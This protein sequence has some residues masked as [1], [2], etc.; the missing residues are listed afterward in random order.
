MHDVLSIASDTPR[1]SVLPFTTTQSSREEEALA[2][3]VTLGITYALYAIT[4]RELFVVTPPPVAEERE[5][6]ERIA[7]AKRL[8]VRYLITG[9][10]SIDGGEVQVDVQ[11]LDANAGIVVWQDQFRQ[12]YA[13]AFKLQ[14]DISRRIVSSL[15]IELST[16]EWNR[17]QFL[18]DTE[19]LKAWLYAADG[20]RHLIRVTPQE[21][22]LAE[23]AYRNALE[24][25]P[26]YVSARRGLAWVAFLSVRLGWSR[27]RVAAIQE[28]ENQ[29]NVVLRK[30]PDDGTSL[31]LKG[32]IL[33]LKEQY[34]EAIESGR[35]AT[36]KL[37]GSADA[38]AVLAHTLTYVG[39]YEDA[40]K[41]IDRAM[42]LS[43]IDPAWYAWTKGRALRMS[44]RIEESIAV[45]EGALRNGPHTIVLLT[46][47]TASYAA[48]GR[49]ADATG[50]ARRIRA[51]A[52]GFTATEWLSHPP[53]Q[54]PDTQSREWE[55]LSK[56][57]L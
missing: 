13:Q 12:P 45:L 6:M 2:Q 15:G 11:C 25:D 9:A 50:L 40:L 35:E 5:Q 33:L 18:D 26:N 57:G 47:L 44:G 8:G 51:A 41:S 29:L 34:D 28:A 56:A 1:I 54:D 43:A 20:V 23:E 19:N 21:V 7:F 16:A 53:V 48:A 52:P 38:W 30:R 10:V 46:E 4:D 32:A 17:I 31:S 49:M 14:D 3:G 22:Q 27:D 39:E 36:E 37:P 24:R 42:S 55:Y